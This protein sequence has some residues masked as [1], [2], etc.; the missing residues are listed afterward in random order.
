M[1]STSQPGSESL[2]SQFPA[3]AQRIHGH[4]LVYLDNAATSQKP[5]AVL[6]AIRDAYVHRCG[7]VHR[8][9]HHLSQ[10]ATSAYEGARD[11]VAAFLS[12]DSRE[13]IVFTRGTTEAINLVAQAI[14][15][16]RLSAGDNVV[17]S[18]ME[19]HSNIVPWQLIA[20]AR[21]V[22]LRVLPFDDDGQL[23]LDLLDQVLDGR[24]RFVAVAHVS[25]TLGTVNDVRHIAEA[26]REVGALTV[27]DGAQAVA[28][29]PV[30]VPA[31]GCD[32]YAFS[33]H[34]IY[35]PTG[36]GVLW[37]RRELLEAMPP[38][39][40][41]GDMIL[42]V[43]FAGSTWADL[44]HKLEAGTP[45][46]AGVIGLGAALEWVE[47]VGL[48]AIAAHGQA[49]L[50]RATEALEALEDVRLIGRAPNKAPVLSFL[51]DDLHPHDVGTILDM[52]GIA[53][54]T[55]HHCT[56]PTMDHYGISATVRASFAAYNDE[57]DVDRLVAGLELV[58]ET[59]R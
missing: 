45:N 48:P 24:T 53:V 19:H 9:V 13:E 26:A 54:R 31:L 37:G 44:P 12:V 32:F 18:E 51:L 11:R 2:R 23:R 33:A 43:S 15:G 46:I 38:W 1:A 39:Q 3:L 59:F 7:N 21:G 49:L 25:N 52:Q 41:G 40:G 56:Q 16:Q 58:R 35:G 5:Q 14:G 47:G 8:G 57:R 4:P 50:R 30:D 42:S 20:E 28:H 36:V 27:V 22:E 17:V 29:L 34:K 6:D 10:A 55:G